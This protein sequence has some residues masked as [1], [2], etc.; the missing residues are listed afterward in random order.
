MPNSFSLHCSLLRANILQPLTS[1]PTLTL[2]QDAI[3]ELLENG[4]L[5]FNAAHGLSQLPPD[6]DKLCSRLALTPKDS[7]DAG[8]K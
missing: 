8:V 2:R 4:D 6:L 5:A 1:I 3:Q 7:G